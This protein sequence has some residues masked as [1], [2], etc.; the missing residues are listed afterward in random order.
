MNTDSKP[1]LHVFCDAS[2]KAYGAVA[3]VVTSFSE[4]LT[5]R[6]RV[7]PI[8]AP[9]LPR[10]ELLA[11]L[12]GAKL[13]EHITQVLGYINFTHIY[14]WADSECSMQ[15]VRNNQSNIVFVRNQ[16]AKI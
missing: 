3:Y 2:G 9:T 16:V 4:L 12:V 1:E 6:A 7:T 5:S 13:I 8:Q 15:W 11:L 10:L 14:V